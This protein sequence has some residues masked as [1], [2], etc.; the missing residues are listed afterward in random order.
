MGHEDAAEGLL[1]PHD[2]LFAPELFMA[3]KALKLEEVGDF[4]DPHGD[5]KSSLEAFHIISQHLFKAQGTSV[6][7]S[8]SKTWLSALPISMQSHKLPM[9]CFHRE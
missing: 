8:S 1:P 4:H 5:L 9:Q 3:W 7:S 6:S 2:E